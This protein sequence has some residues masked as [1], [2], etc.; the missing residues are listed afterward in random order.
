M[1]RFFTRLGSVFLTLFLVLGLLPM[2][3]FAAE[4]DVVQLTK[5]FENPVGYGSLQDAFS[6]VDRHGTTIK[7]ISNVDFSDEIDI[8]QY[9]VTID[10]NGYNLTGS[11]TL[12]VSGNGGLTIIETNETKTGKVSCN[13]SNE[14]KGTYLLL[15]G[16][17][18]SGTITGQV[19]ADE[20]SANAKFSTSVYESIESVPLTIAGHELVKNGDWYEFQAITYTIVLHLNGGILV[21]NDFTETITNTYDDKNVPV[22]KREQIL[23]QNYTFGGWYIDEACTETQAVFPTNGSLSAYRLTTYADSATHVLN[24]YAKWTENSGS[25]D[26]DMFVAIGNNGGNNIFL[27]E[28]TPYYV[29]G[30]NAASAEAETWNAYFDVVNNALYLDGLNITESLLVPGGI[31]IHVQGTNT[32]DTAQAA[33]P[34]IAWL[35]NGDVIFS[36]DGSLT[37]NSSGEYTIGNEISKTEGTSYEGGVTIGG[38]VKLNVEN[39]QASGSCILIYGQSCGVEIKDNAEVTLKNLQKNG[40]CIRVKNNGDI[41][42]SD[43]AKLEGTGVFHIEDENLG[44]GTRGSLIIGSSNPVEI[45]GNDSGQNITIYAKTV[46]VNGGATLNIQNTSRAVSHQQLGTNLSISGTMNVSG[47]QDAANGMKIDHLDITSTGSLT[48]K[49]ED[50]DTQ[51]MISAESVSINGTLN[52]NG[53]L[54]AIQTS[55]SSNGGVVVDGGSVSMKNVTAGMVVAYSGDVE[56]KTNS[57]IEIEAS[58]TGIMI[59]SDTNATGQIKLSDCTLKITGGNRAFSGP[60]FASLSSSEVFA[61]DSVDTKEKVLAPNDAT[62]IQKYVEIS[63]FSE[64]PSS[65][66]GTISYPPI[67]TDTENGSVSVGPRNP[68]RGEEVTI[69]PRPDQG[70]EV[71]EIIVTDCN[72][73]EVEITD[74]GDGSYS[75]EQPRGRVTVEITFK[76]AACDGGA[77]CPSAHLSDIAVDAWYHAAV[78][79]VVA[80]GL[81]E[82]TSATAFSPDEPFTR[83]MLATILWRLEESPVVNYQLSFND[84]AEGQWYTE[85]VRWAASEEIVGGYG[86]GSFRPEDAVSR[87][88]MAAIFYRYAQHKGYDVSVGEDTNIL[89]YADAAMISEYAIPAMQWACGAGVIE[90]NGQL[91]TP[92]ADTPRCQA[93]AVLMRF[94]EGVAQ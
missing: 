70:Y 74:N 79:Y 10:L 85:A 32:I 75:F 82:G 31:T 84:V 5:P 63:L 49:T 8:D 33:T 55:A 46:T 69:T 66:S 86:D 28:S 16:G 37:V 9:Y 89:S 87:E 43:N 72:G 35:S 23:R 42:V 6:A 29:N 17:A 21:G 15:N 3:A 58:N 51:L 78:D 73:N 34:G 71:D 54:Y 57:N 22:P 76:P 20:S 39:T 47:I 50:A 40:Y 45:D 18:Y 77:D 25:I 1:K 67:I 91:L 19:S 64:V 13:L 14:L 11:G 26:Q 52:V 59:H 83:G 93:A 2:S 62:W 24:L 38:D 30:S 94:C 90:G 53:G 92:Q 68:E 44:D 81:M 4:D 36:G 12:K 7:L 80:N 65:S 60:V 61:G 27:T 88:E 48:M 56:I 41:K